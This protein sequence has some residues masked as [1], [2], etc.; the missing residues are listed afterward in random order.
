MQSLFALALVSCLLIG[1]AI[2]A[3]GAVPAAGG[4]A[5]APE[6]AD[7]D[8][9]KIRRDRINVLL[10]RIM[11]E[12]KIEAWLTFTRENT[13]DPL[14]PVLG[15]DH[16]VA[17][18]AFLFSLKD[19]DFRKVAIAASYDVDPIRKSG[20]YDEVIPYRSEG[21]KPHLR[22]AID[23]LDPTGIAVNHSRDVTIADGLTVGLRAY[24]DEALGPHAAKFTSSERLVVS[25]LGRKLPEEIRALERAVTG[26]QQVI[27]EALT[28]RVVVPGTTTEN[29]LNDWMMAR[30]R[31]LGFGIAFTSVVVGPQRGHSEP[32]DRVI[33]RGDV[34]RIDWGASYGGYCADIQRT[35]YVLREGEDSAPGWLEKLWSATLAANRA[36]IAALKPGNTGND[37]DRAGRGSL[38]AAGYPEFPHGTGHA[39]GL[40]VHDVGPML[41]PDWRERY[42]DPVFFAIEP[43]QVFAVEPLIY[44]KPDE[45]GY[46]FH[47]SLEED[48]VVT[49]NGARYI[50]APQSELILIR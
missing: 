50:G 16:I 12:Q 47:T 20:L 45:I 4:P 36:A 25:L 30:A 38:V 10:P 44:V 40:K 42:G 19:G 9:D 32:T 41:G 21:V 34:I 27:R 24:L 5:G 33:E 2:A 37:V 39:I 23:A 43:D 18:G 15:V 49:E 3:G 11:K 29:D 1:A 31:E 22:K 6:A 17:R 48:L 35:A 46:D 14:L 8:H 7:V 26:T 13:P 28:S